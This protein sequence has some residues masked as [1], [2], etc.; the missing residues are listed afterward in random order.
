MEDEY[1]EYVGDPDKIV[2]LFQEGLDELG[3]ETPI[4]DITLTYLTS[5]STTEVQAEREYIQQ[6]LEETLGL[7]V[8]LSVAGD[9]SLFIADRMKEIMT[10]SLAAGI[11]ITM[12]RLTSYILTILML[13]VCPLVDT[14]TLIMMH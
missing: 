5:G 12:I 9:T 2:A 3:V 13:T 8:E 14:A 11:Q 10:S 7:T 4:E 6:S 1:N